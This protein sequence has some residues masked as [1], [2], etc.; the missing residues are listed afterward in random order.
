MVP[1][2]LLAIA[3][4]SLTSGFGIVQVARLW[5]LWPVT[6]IATGMEEIYLWSISKKDR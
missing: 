5:S 3:L 1:L 6:L 4:L 2:V